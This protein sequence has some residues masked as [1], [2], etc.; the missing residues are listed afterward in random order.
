MNL[1]ICEHPV[2]VYSKSLH[3]FTYVRCGKCNTC[4]NIRNNT[5]TDR[6]IQESQYWKY[7]VFFTLTFDDRHVP[8]LTLDPDGHTLVD[9][10]DGFSVD[11]YDVPGFSRDMCSFKRKVYIYK[12]KFIPYVSVDIAQKF[13]KRL[14]YYFNTLL[15]FTP[16]EKILRYFL[17]SEYG[18]STYRPHLHGLLFFSSPIF[19]VRF[20]EMLCKAWTFG[21]VDCSFV[22]DSAASYVARYI[23]CNYALP[24][25][26]LHRQ[27]RPFV[28][29]SKCPAIGTLQVTSQELSQ[30]F[31]KGIVR[32]TIQ[33]FK[34]NT[35]KDVPLWR[36]LKDK[37]FPKIQSFDSFTHS[38]R[39]TLYGASKYSGEEDFKEFAFWC[40]KV[41]HQSDEY[42]LDNDTFLASYLRYLYECDS[43]SS[44]PGFS[45]ALH[46]FF[47]VSRR[48]CLQASVFGVSLDYYVDRIENFYS[49]NALDTL[50]QFY[51]FQIE[52]IRKYKDP[53]P[54]VFMYPGL[55]ERFISV[56]LL[57]GSEE[58]LRHVSVSDYYLLENFGFI[59]PDFDFG[60]ASFQ[61]SKAFDLFS[62]INSISVNFNYK[63]FKDSLKIKKKNDYL[64]WLERNDHYNKT[65]GFNFFKDYA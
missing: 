21:N 44:R 38:Q 9:V 57:P 55:V 32:R 3:R 42:G 7:T 4:R 6:L 40:M 37:L 30:I 22:K 10:N 47:M 52:F 8:M 1:S 27:I 28:L 25:I 16:D 41:I 19:A 45:Y 43:S 60:L 33:D 51:E 24:G 64:H 54:L 58:Q 59:N 53:R 5:W 39:V 62:R 56:G 49:V 61:L 26:Y 17:V 18:P 23:D 2:R 35:F 46:N 13:L 12:R 63:I 11:L 31:H 14:R 48:V 65:F 20:E 36:S 50:K 15:K 34:R 29:F